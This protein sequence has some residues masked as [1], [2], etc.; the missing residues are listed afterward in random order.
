MKIVVLDRATLGEDVSLSVLDGFGEVCVYGM[1]APHEVAERIA[2]CDV[3][4][5]NKIKLNKI[6]LDQAR[7][8]RLI[9]ITATGYDN[10]DCAYCKARGIAVCNVVGYSTQ[11]VAQVTVAMALT[12]LATG[13]RNLES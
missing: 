10:V 13:A 4:I 1:T 6:N 8:L 11:S 12:T 3:V 2:D 7:S 5:V 9:C